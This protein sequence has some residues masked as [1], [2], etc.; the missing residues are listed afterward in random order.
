MTPPTAPSAGER[1][2]WRV[3]DRRGWRSDVYD[4]ETAAEYAR[5]WD[6][7]CPDDAPHTV[8]VD[9][10]AAPRVR[11]TD[12]F[13]NRH[14]VEKKRIQSLALSTVSGYHYHL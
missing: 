4:R 3:R 10:V 8:E 14:A 13:D 5:L 7:D 2:M 6:R 1:S 9:D 11:I 12:V